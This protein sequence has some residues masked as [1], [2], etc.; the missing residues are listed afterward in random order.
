MDK[1]KISILCEYLDNT[2]AERYPVSNKDLA[3]STDYIKNGYLKMLAVVMQQSG[4]ITEPQLKMFKRIIAGADTDKQAEDFLRMA[5]D[6]EIDDYIQFSD[7]CKDLQLK[8]RWMLDAMI[9]TCVQDR[10]DEQLKLIAQFAESYEITKEELEY[11]AT[12]AKAIIA[13]DES[14]YVSAYEVKADSISDV[15]FSDYM[16]LISKKCVCSNDNMTIFQPTH[17]QNIT[18]QMLEKIEELNT[19]C[20]KIIGANI[21]ADDCEILFKNR[22]KVILEGCTFT[23]GDKR[24]IYFNDC[25]EIII[26]NCEFKDFSTRT[27]IFG[28]A[29]KVL[30]IGSRFNNCNLK[31]SNSANDWPILGGVLHSNNPS[32]VGKFDL[33]DTSFVECGGINNTFNATPHSAFISNIDS[34]VDKCSFTN[35]WHKRNGNIDPENSRRTMFTPQSKATN[36]TYEDSARF[37]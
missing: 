35:C 24:S 29:D 13:M 22:E 27:I 30:V 36:C 9:V 31:Y 16:Y 3:E 20:V 14:A 17:D 18:A 34:S 7:E 5:L 26:N 33:I 23:G 4:T 28:K 8:Y 37:N 6:I 15:I 10:T 1:D 12:M 25:K 2:V 21:R 19:P 11:I 32:N